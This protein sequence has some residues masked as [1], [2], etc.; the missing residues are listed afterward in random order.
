MQPTVNPSPANLVARP[1][2]R[3]RIVKAGIKLAYAAP[4]VAYSFKLT[5][6][7]AAGISGVR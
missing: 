2:T 6:E 7:R 4:L 3:R 5:E 1:A